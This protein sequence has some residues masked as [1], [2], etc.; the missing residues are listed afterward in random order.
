VAKR[1]KGRRGRRP[2]K[3]VLKPAEPEV[4]AKPVR[5]TWG[6]AQVDFDGEWGWRKLVGEDCERLHR[7][8]D[9]FESEQLVT[10]RKKRWVKLI[11]P[12][13]MV[14]D[15]QK[16]LKEIGRDDPEGLWQLHLAH[17][18]WR[19]WGF[20][21][22]STFYVLWWDPDHSVATGKSRTRSS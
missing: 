20:L 6:L 4:P 7:E 10:L 1:V 21:E 22:D 13:D 9:A 14:N 2:P 18:K 19:V 8:M 15:A 11:P 3:R 16:R 5:L 12:K 17:N